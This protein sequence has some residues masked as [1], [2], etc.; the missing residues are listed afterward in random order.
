MPPQRNDTLLLILSYF[1]LYHYSQVADN[2]LAI[3]HYIPHRTELYI[4]AVHARLARY[5]LSF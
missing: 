1:R 3:L 4:I 2:E 5:S